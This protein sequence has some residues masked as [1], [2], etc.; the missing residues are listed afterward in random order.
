MQGLIAGHNCVRFVSII[1]RF[2]INQ[3]PEDGILFKPEIKRFSGNAHCRAGLRNLATRFLEGHQKMEFFDERP[4]LG[5][6]ERSNLF[7]PGGNDF[8]LPRGSGRI[9]TAMLL[10]HSFVPRIGGDPIGAHEE[11][12]KARIDVIA[13]YEAL[14]PFDIVFAEGYYHDL[15]TGEYAEEPLVI[16]GGHFIG[17]GRQD[18]KR[19]VFPANAHDDGLKINVVDFLVQSVFYENLDR[20]EFADEP[21]AE[22]LQEWRCRGL[23]EYHTYITAEV[24][25]SLCHDRLAL[26]VIAE[27]RNKKALNAVSES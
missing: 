18:K 14:Q 8:L 22:E 9:R 27:Y 15:M 4:K 3:C 1:T 19:I 10:H 23:T 7:K 24:R 25:R 20:F 16:I 17:T 11:I 21:F 5:F 26:E 2:H 13:L 6:L 12:Y